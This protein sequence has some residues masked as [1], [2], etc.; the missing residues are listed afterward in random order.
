MADINFKNKMSS[1]IVRGICI[2][3]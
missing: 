3:F 2:Y 1:C